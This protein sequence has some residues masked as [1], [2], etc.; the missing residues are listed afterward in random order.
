MHGPMIKAHIM[1]TS[2]A[3]GARNKEALFEER[4][5]APA[6]KYREFEDASNQ[7][8]LSIS[9]FHLGNNYHINIVIIFVLNCLQHALPNLYPNSQCNSKPSHHGILLHIQLSKFFQHLP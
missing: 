5:C 4:S 7:V 8:R 1:I 9:I 3:E 6:K 2:I